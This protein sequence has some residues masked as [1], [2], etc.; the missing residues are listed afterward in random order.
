MTDWSALGGN[1]VPGDPGSIR[2]AATV[3]DGIVSR[4]QQQ[5]RL[6]NGIQAGGTSSW[7]GQAANGFRAS[8]TALGPPIANVV[9]CHQEASGALKKFAGQLTAFQATAGQL[10]AHAQQQQRA[11][12]SAETRAGQLYPQVSTAQSAYNRAY[13]ST[14]MACPAGPPSLTPVEGPFA[15]GSPGAL[16]QAYQAVHAQLAQAESDWKTAQNKLSS[17]QGQ[18]NTLN[19]QAAAA[20]QAC[21]NT[22]DAATQ[23]TESTGSGNSVVNLVSSPEFNLAY[24]YLMIP[25]QQIK[26]LENEAEKSAKLLTKAE[27]DEQKVLA[28]I[29]QA[30]RDLKSGNTKAAQ[31]A[32][33]KL[34]RDSKQT[35]QDLAKTVADNGDAQA[36]AAKAVEDFDGSWEANLPSKAVFAVSKGLGYT[37]VDAYK[38]VS[39]K[40]TT[41]GDASA[42]TIAEESA[43][44][45]GEA[46]GD[47]VPVVGTVIAGS[48]VAYDLSTHQYVQAA[49]NGAGFVAT[50]ATGTALVL[51]TATPVGWVVIGSAAAGI[52]VSEG[53]DH[54]KAIEH[55]GKSIL[56]YPGEFANKLAHDLN[57]ANFLAG[58]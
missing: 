42:A 26:D 52:L 41:G 19:G 9:S 38:T 30:A 37:W 1:P 7:Q 11:V 49:G 25:G 23:P 51:L 53:I 39:N 24:A 20:A 32:A 8:V 31:S 58:G 47:N 27:E 3:L 17:L 21:A 6:M 34:L 54:Y 55:V 22:I 48:L 57:P 15:I 4:V 44:G 12:T 45:V 16:L 40:L 36:D 14:A 56:D 2:A 5:N 46:L 33:G 35:K 10:L 43:G 50:V 18:A 13:E 28:D 29:S